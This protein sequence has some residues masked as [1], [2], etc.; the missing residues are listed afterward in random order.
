MK[1]KYK[2]FNEL[3]K[4]IN[5]FTKKTREKPSKNK[6]AEIIN[7]R[8]RKKSNKEEVKETKFCKECGEKI[9]AKAEICPKCGCRVEGP[10]TSAQPQ[11]IINN[12][13]DSCNKTESASPPYGMKPR[14]IS[15]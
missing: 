12:T 4:P 2:K 9:P 10:P 8:I 11:I 15:H 6:R 14:M 7:Q 1:K 3:H 5:V 13:N